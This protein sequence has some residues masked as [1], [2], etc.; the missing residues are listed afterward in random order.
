MRYT[1]AI[2][3]CK[4]SGDEVL[5]SCLTPAPASDRWTHQRAAAPVVSEKRPD[6]TNWHMTNADFYTASQRSLQDQ[7]ESRPLADRIEMAVVQPELEDRHTSF[8]SSRD[9][10]YLATVNSD[11]EPTVSYKGGGIGVVSVVN[12][13]TL[14]FPIYDGNGMFL[15]AGNM[16]D[17]GKVGLLFMDFETP[18]RVRV[19]GDASV[20]TDDEL[21]ETYPGALLICRIAVTSVFIN[22]ARYIHK[23]TRVESSQYVPDESGDQPLASWKRIDGVQDV[24]SPAVQSQVLDAGGVITDQEY[25]EMLMKG[26]S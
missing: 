14:A 20:H 19:Q 16:A 25:G 15:S 18:Q 4:G 11:G 26:E 17:T 23:H 21:L 22:C 8:I 10:F 3:R 7:F 2:H 24:L 9:F 13:T 6:M 1:D 5:A 12:S